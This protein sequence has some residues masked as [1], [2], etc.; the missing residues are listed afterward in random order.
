MT[1]DSNRAFRDYATRISFNLS[2]SRNQV[3][4]M[5]SVAIAIEANGGK[6]IYVGGADDKIGVST[7][8]RNQHVAQRSA[9]DQI[10]NMFVPGSRSLEAN[11]LLQHARNDKGGITTWDLTPAGWH[12]IALL[13]IAGLIPERA[14]NSNRKPRVKAVARKAP[15]RVQK[16]RRAA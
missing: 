12:I 13:R 7:D 15:A 8:Y 6:P 9:G 5:R 1:I 10:P 11:G 14:A 4:I 2:L 16:R 3:A